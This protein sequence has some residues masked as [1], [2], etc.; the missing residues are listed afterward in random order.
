MKNAKIIK[1][2]QKDFKTASNL[3]KEYYEIYGDKDTVWELEDLDAMR[4][5]GQEF[6]EIFAIN[7]KN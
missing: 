3:Y 1:L 5:V 2:S 7:F 6:M 4:E